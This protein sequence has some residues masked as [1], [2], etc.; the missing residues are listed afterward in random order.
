MGLCYV[1]ADVWLIYFRF[2]LAKDFL[3]QWVTL[4]SHVNQS[5]VSSSLQVSPHF[6]F[7]F[8]VFGLNSIQMTG[9]WAGRWSA[10]NSSET[11]KEMFKC[12]F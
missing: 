1:C 11:E 6:L 2:G 5:S 9:A 3:R 8:H 7:F 10:D 12:L 4:L